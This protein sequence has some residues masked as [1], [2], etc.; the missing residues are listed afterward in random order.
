MTVSVARDAEALKSMRV[1]SSGEREALRVEILL[2]ARR[3]T[4]LDDAVLAIERLFAVAPEMVRD[5]ELRR[6]LVR[7]AANGGDTARAAFRVITSSMGSDGPDLLYQIMTERPSLAEQAKFLL[8]R[9]RVRKLFSPELAIAYDLRFSPSCTS[10]RGLLKRAAEIGDQ[11]SINTLS[12]L[13]DNP[14]HCGEPGRFPCL[15]LCPS[16]ELNF[17]KAIDAIVRRVRGGERAASMN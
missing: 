15:E 8:S 17:T 4:G 6:I 10:R 7:A 13:L 2:H 12:A 9:T 3:A 11:R 1:G 16:E 14:P 5:P